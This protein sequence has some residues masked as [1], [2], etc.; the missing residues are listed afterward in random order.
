[1][2]DLPGVAVAIDPAP[3]SGWLFDRW[4]GDVSADQR[5]DDP[6][7]LLMDQNR[8]IDPHFMQ[9]G[10]LSADQMIGVTTVPTCI[11][12]EVC[13]T[14]SAPASVSAEILNIAGR[15]VKH[16]VSNRICDA[17]QQSLAWNGVSDYGT[18]APHG[19]YL[20]RVTAFGHTGQRSERLTTV[21]LR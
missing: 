1:M 11:G 10:D 18:R 2:S 4:S 8:T 20:I 7:H 19:T 12:A 6:I 17:G 16:L 13:F 3:R 15:T 21:Q 9:D 14:L 5:L